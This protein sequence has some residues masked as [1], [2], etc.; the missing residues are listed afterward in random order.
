MSTATEPTANGLDDPTP[1]VAETAPPASASP[2]FRFYLHTRPV[3][4][5]QYRA[6]MDRVLGCL[7]VTDS[8]GVTSF[9]PFTPRSILRDGDWVV[10]VGPAQPADTGMPQVDGMSV[11]IVPDSEFRSE[12]RPAHPG[13]VRGTR[14]A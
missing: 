7:V 8:Q 12:Y 1:T 6:G 10:D 3:R 13:E 4:A 14:N 9:R 11:R 2:P 5:E